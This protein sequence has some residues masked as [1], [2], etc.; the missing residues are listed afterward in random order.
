[1]AF[2]I[3]ALQHYLDGYHSW[4]LPRHCLSNLCQNLFFFL[5]GFLSI[6]ACSIFQ[7][8]PQSLPAGATTEWAMFCLH[9][10][11]HWIVFQNLIRKHKIILHCIYHLLPNPILTVLLFFSISNYNLEILTP[12]NFWVQLQVAA[13]LGELSNKVEDG[14]AY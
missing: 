6:T 11:R 7:L 4:P 12:S 10:L 3:M 13:S 9:L 14:W 5:L 8:F 1:M 2:S